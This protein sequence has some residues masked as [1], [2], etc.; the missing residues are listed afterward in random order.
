M[1]IICIS[2]IMMHYAPEWGAEVY[3]LGRLIVF[4]FKFSS[5]L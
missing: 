4:K 2:S 1:E 5:E 3:V